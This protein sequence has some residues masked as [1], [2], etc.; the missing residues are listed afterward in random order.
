MVVEEGY[1]LF[2][3]YDTVNGIPDLGHSSPE[4]KYIQFQ[5]KI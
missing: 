4:N 1:E 3:P 5:I 2:Y